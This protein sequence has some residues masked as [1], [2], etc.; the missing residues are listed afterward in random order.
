MKKFSEKILEYKGSFEI[1]SKEIADYTKKMTKQLP[2]EVQ[3]VLY[4]LNK[5]SIEDR[6]IIDKIK[7][8]KKSDMVD[9]ADKYQIPLNELEDI[10]KQLRDLKTMI[11]LLPQ[12]QTKMERESFMSGKLAMDDITMDLDSETGR[13]NIAKQY[14][15]IVFKLVK[16]FEGTSPLSKEELLSAGMVGLTY[17]MNTFRKP[18]EIDN[19]IFG[20]EIDKKEAMKA[21]SLSFKQYAAWCIRNK[22]FYDIQKY[23][24][25]IRMGQY[26]YYKTKGDEVQPIY[27]SL[28]KT[29][30]NEHFNIDYFGELAQT[31][32]SRRG[33]DRIWKKLFDLISNRFPIRDVII[34]KKYFGLEE[35]EKEKATS[36][37]KEFKISNSRVTFIINNIIKFLKNDR[38]TKDLLSDIAD[39]YNE[40]LFVQ[41]YQMDQQIIEESL[42]NDDIYLLL[43][44]I[45]RWS[46][47]EVFKNHIITVTNKFSVDEARFIY[48]CLTNGFEWLDS[49]YKKNKSLIIWFL[50][51]MYPTETIKRK[52]DV[53]ILEMMEE[54][55][56]TN[57]KFNINWK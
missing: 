56:D 17:A 49:N 54:L 35:Y 46:D 47:K 11:R 45:N 24:H 19:D 9:I 2:R 48:D 31:G 51:E 52:S 6:E 18:D 40:A 23:S 36:I 33:E 7:H 26:G 29:S 50:S 57:N 3:I 55:I 14:A 42:L 1:I 10:K 5:Y 15:P 43:E 27:I 25:K 39:M 20:D 44:E 22:I 32:S 41:L 37:A 34:F 38:D 8:G 30:D 12:Y 4:M 21:K 13:N 28:D 53:E 16:Q